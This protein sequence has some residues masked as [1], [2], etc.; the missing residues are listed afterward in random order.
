MRAIGTTMEGMSTASIHS[1]PPFMFRSKKKTA[2]S[3]F[4]LRLGPVDV[5]QRIV[6]D[7]QRLRLSV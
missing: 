6:A 3:L 5:F 7:A 4:N 2:F 1:S